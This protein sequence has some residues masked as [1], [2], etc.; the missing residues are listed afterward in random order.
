MLVVIVHPQAKATLDPSYQLAMQAL[1]AS[2]NTTIGKCQFS[3][4]GMRYTDPDAIISVSS[5]GVFFPAASWLRAFFHDAGT[6]IKS[7][8]KGGPKGEGGLHNAVWNRAHPCKTRL[9]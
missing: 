6:F 1:V 8:S 2:F 5:S 4:E 7:P 9:K 3:L